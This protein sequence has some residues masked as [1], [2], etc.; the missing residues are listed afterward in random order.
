MQLSPHFALEELTITDHRDMLDENIKL[1][2]E[3][4]TLTSLKKV[5]NDLLEPVRTKFG[6]PV[7]VH[8]GF[9]YPALNSVVGGSSTSQHMVGEAVD[10]LIEGYSDIQG[11][12]E[13]MTKIIK[14]MPEL[15]FGQLL[16]EAGCLHISL[17]TKKQVAFY[18]VSKKEKIPFDPDNVD[19]NDIKP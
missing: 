13:V 16:I 3:E 10:F 6:A 7:H 5:A 14:E 15:Q 11:K 8:S 19:I 4:P 17:G 2:Q 12:V 18:S 9:R 1:A